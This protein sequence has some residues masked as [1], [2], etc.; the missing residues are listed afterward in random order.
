MKTERV[1]RLNRLILQQLSIVIMAEMEVADKA[2]VSIVNVDTAKDLSQAK[3]FVSIFAPDEEKRAEI[4]SKLV[5]QLKHL[6]YELAQRLELRKTPRLIFV[7]DESI[8][9]GEKVL[10]LIDKAKKE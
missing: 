1:T 9:S 6:R 2:I 8:E 4:F 7:L 3:I 5:K 10:N